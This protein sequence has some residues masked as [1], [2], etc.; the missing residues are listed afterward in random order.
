MFEVIQID[1]CFWTELV[2]VEF[3]A[4]SDPKRDSH[5]MNV[6]KKFAQDRYVFTEKKKQQNTKY[7]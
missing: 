6:F 4:C 1:F 7:L 3:I 5:Q 2:Q